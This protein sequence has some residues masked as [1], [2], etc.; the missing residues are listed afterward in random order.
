MTSC[1]TREKRRSEAIPTPAMRQPMTD[2][3]G[4]KYADQMEER[5]KGP[6]QSDF[7]STQ[8]AF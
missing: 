3:L 4:F 7:L 2:D 6:F 5:L 1:L 8:E